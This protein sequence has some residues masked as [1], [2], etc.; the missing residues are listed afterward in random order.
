M[1]RFVG[2]QGAAKKLFR[3]A[4]AQVRLTISFAINDSSLT[5]EHKA[6]AGTRKDLCEARLHI[7]VRMRTFLIE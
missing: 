3:S 4:F 5:F 7:G 2:G 1:H 6:F